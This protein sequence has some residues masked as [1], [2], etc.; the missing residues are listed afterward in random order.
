MTFLRQN[1]IINFSEK[2]NNT[3]IIEAFIFIFIISPIVD[4]IVTRIIKKNVK[5]PRLL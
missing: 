5:I 3:K 2:K 1:F 4:E